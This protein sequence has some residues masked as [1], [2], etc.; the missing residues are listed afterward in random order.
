MTLRVHVPLFP[1]SCSLIDASSCGGGEGRRPSCE[2][3]ATPGVGESPPGGRGAQVSGA[4]AHRALGRLAEPDEVD[5]GAAE[6]DAGGRDRYPNSLLAGGGRA[7]I[8]EELSL[9]HGVD[10]LVGACGEPVSEAMLRLLRQQLRRRVASHPP[11][12]EVL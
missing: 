6:L 11:A 3:T 7:P 12:Q 2:L 10:Q 9:G 5:V 1:A 4:R 8:L